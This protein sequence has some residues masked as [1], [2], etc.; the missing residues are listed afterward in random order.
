LMG[1]II[2]AQTEIKASS[3]SLQPKT[4][5]VRWMY[6]LPTLFL[7]TLIAQFDKL[8]ISI[9]MANR[10]F[11][12]DMQLLSNPTLVGGLVSAFLISYGVG[13][14]VW[15]PIIDRIGPRRSLIVGVAAWSVTLVWGGMSETLPMLYLSRIGLGLSEAV[16]YPVCNAYVVRWF[17]LHER[18]RAQSFW[19]NGA[20]VGAAVGSALVTAFV[21]AGGWRVAFFALAILGVV[22]LLPMVVLLTKDD[23]EKHPKVSPEELADIRQQSTL[24]VSPKDTGSSI[25]RDYR[26]WLLV[27][28]FVANN[29]FFWGWAGWLPTYL[30]QARHFS[31]NSAG[32]VTALMFGI[33]IIAV[34][35]M[36]YWTD[37]IRRRATLGAIGFFL[38]SLGV[39][40]GGVIENIPLGLALMIFGVSCQQAGAGNIQALLHSFSSKQF[41]GRAAGIMNGC[42]NTVSFFAPM[43]IG[44]MIGLKNGS[45]ST[46]ISFLAVDLLVSAVALALLIRSKY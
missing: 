41:M 33:E 26:Y 19:F 46:V 9:I 16:L 6:I 2:M 32:W 10:A 36:G 44:A 18:G 35:L 34:L 40:A 15:G 28:S 25:L 1:G 39:Y 38:A 17:A 8:S 27:I 14:F 12:Q 30:M 43:V 31:F 23:P 29:V 22:I 11:L 13:Q 5:R 4:T 24:E 3:V 7:A 37:R 45:F 20:T 21:V 42:A